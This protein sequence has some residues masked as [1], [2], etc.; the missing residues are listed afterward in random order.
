MFPTRCIPTL[1][2]ED[3]PQAPI[4]T[5]S[6]SPGLACINPKHP[7]CQLPPLQVLHATTPSTHHDNFHLSRSCMQQPQAPIMTTSTSPG[8]ACNNP[9]H[10]SCQLPPLQVLH[11]TTPST[12]HDNFHLSRSCMQQPQAPI[13][14]TS[15]SPG[16]ACINPKHPSCQLPPLQV[17]HATTPS[18]HHVNFHLSRSCMQQPQAPIMSTSTSPGLA[19]N[20]PKHPS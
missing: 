10:P 15:T 4:M 1:A 8:L 19:C 2:L 12:H 13:M 5:T 18:T 9:K 3:I 6:T 14:T 17:L 16:L 7:S 20:N 11:A